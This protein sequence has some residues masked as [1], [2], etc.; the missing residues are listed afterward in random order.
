MK[1]KNP[2]IFG[3]G[4][5]NPEELL[6]GMC[7][8]CKE[9]HTLPAKEWAVLQKSKNK[10]RLICISSLSEEERLSIKNK[11]DTKNE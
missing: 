8:R 1:I 7:F 2:K 3:Y 6:I 9:K 11:V 5:D 10:F 4:G